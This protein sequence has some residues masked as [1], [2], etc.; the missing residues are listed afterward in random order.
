M[1]AATDAVREG[2]GLSGDFV[3]YFYSSFYPKESFSQVMRSAYSFFDLSAG[4]H[5]VFPLKVLSM[6]LGAVSSP[7]RR[8]RDYELSILT[9]DPGL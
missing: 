1:R 9:G 6:G 7:G 4:F 3:Y 8:R 2:M 5:S